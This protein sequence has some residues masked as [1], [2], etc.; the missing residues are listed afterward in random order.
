MDI[1]DL[2]PKVFSTNPETDDAKRQWVHWFKLFTT[3][4][5]KLGEESAEDKLN[6]LM[7]HVDAT[8]YE[9]IS[10]APD[11]NDAINL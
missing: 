3:Y 8:I 9:L 5:N 1:K 11:Y 6:L 4:I 10:E 2:L 7:N